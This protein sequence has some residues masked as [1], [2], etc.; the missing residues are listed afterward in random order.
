M[1]ERD[2]ELQNLVGAGPDA[3]TSEAFLAF[4]EIPDSLRIE[5]TAKT[6]GRSIDWMSL[7]YSIRKY[8]CPILCLV[9]FAGNLL[10]ILILGRRKNRKKSTAIYLLFLAVSDTVVLYVGYF[11]EWILQ[12][13]HYDI[14]TVN[15]MSCKFHMFV[16]YLSLQYSSWILVLVTCERVISVMAPHRV[17]ML[18]NRQRG[19]VALVA[20]AVAIAVLNSHL[21]IGVTHGYNPYNMRNCT[22]VSEQYMDF[23]VDVWT[24]VD[25][26][27]TFAVPFVFIIVG[28][29]IIIMRLARTNR[30][31]KH[32]LVK[33]R[34]KHSLT[35]MLL[36]LSVVFV[37]STGPAAIYMPVIFPRLVN[38]FDESEM[39]I[40]HFIFDMVNILAGLNA[41]LN[42]ILYFLSGSKFR[43]EVKS[44][45]CCKQHVRH[46]LF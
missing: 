14:R 43:A 20:T 25:V 40:P 1:T 33:E 16:T 29:S 35:V 13:W 7:S 8:S 34:K 18:C 5:T 23:L 4:T 11:C 32:S 45:F 46:E 22:G 19:L 2:S 28:N 12:M 27:V 36:L 3:F 37:I 15:G 9:G 24:M 38:S 6:D 39:A 26:I 21:L 44:F 31:R 41:T 42:F 10:T 30:L 17:R